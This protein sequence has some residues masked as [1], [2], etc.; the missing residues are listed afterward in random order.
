LERHRRTRR[1]L[2]VTQRG[3]ED[4]DAILGIPG[5]IGSDHGGGV[6]FSRLAHRLDS[7]MRPAIIGPA[8]DPSAQFS[9]DPLS[10]ARDP[11]VRALL[12]QGL[13][14]RR[15]R[16]RAR[17]D[18]PGREAVA[19]STDAEVVVRIVRPVFREY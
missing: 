4:N 14:R 18:G 10:T 11:R 6:V 1:L 9:V 15:V 19:V 8:N 3:V 7:F 2:A 13:L 16:L 12:A 5:S 17:N